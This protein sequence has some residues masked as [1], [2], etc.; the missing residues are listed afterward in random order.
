MVWE[1]LIQDQI[2][3]VTKQL[4][5]QVLIVLG[6]YAA[7]VI[8]KR[9]KKG[10]QVVHL[11]IAVVLIIRFV[12]LALLK[13]VVNVNHHLQIPTVP[14]MVNQ[15][16]MTVAMDVVVQQVVS[17]GVQEIVLFLIV[18]LVH[19]RQGIMVHM[20]YTHVIMNVESL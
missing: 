2:K 18:L 12:M 5:V 19:Q 9:E 3:L 7:H 4:L 15:E 17:A 14:N 6:G 16:H 11:V 13:L 1:L 10:I 8:V 20:G